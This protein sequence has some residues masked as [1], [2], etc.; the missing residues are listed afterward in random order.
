MDLNV[1]LAQ[2]FSRK[3]SKGRSNKIPSFLVF[4]S[5]NIANHYF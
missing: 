5:E 4:S 3:I 2:V 1:R